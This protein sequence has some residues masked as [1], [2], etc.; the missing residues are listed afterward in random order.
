ML[1]PKSGHLEDQF[2]L[3]PL[4]PAKR[5][6]RVMNLRRRGLT[7]QIR[8]DVRVI[9][10][11]EEP[12]Y[13]ALSYTW[14]AT[15]KGH[16]ILLNDRYRLSITDNLHNALHRL[17]ARSA[18]PPIWVDAV[19]INQSDVPERSAQVE[20]MGDI[21]RQ[22]KTVR[23]WLGE[24]G[25]P[26]LGH[27]CHALSIATLVKT[28]PPT[29]EWH[30]LRSM[31]Y[32]LALRDANAVTFPGWYNRAW[33]QQEYALAR[34][35]VMHCGSL[36]IS[37]EDDALNAIPGLL[38]RL[39]AIQDLQSSGNLLDAIP[40]NVPRQAKDP[41]DLVYSLRA[42]LFPE[43][44]QLIV[45]DYSLSCETV[46][47]QAT[48]IAIR[49]SGNFNILEHFGTYRSLDLTDLG[50]DLPSWAVDF[51][52]TDWGSESQT[53]FVWPL[54]QEFRQPLASAEDTFASLTIQGVRFGAVG[55][56]L[57][58]VVGDESFSERPTGRF[59]IDRVAALKNHTGRASNG[60]TRHGK[61]ETTSVWALKDAC[62]ELY[63]LWRS[64][65]GESR[66]EG[67]NEDV[68]EIEKFF[69]NTSYLNP[70][71]FSVLAI[72]DDHIALAPHDVRT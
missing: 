41:R 5:Q 57:N 19:C 18:P 6:I 56:V 23:I 67:L 4:D 3:L 43:I 28:K 52:L 59:L 8:A 65:R 61:F 50:L 22:A 46:F 49:T 58:L 15:T 14:G 25:K 62:C 20:M 70:D 66:F 37:R 54:M 38:L 26:M 9:S 42:I 30:G 39:Q 34:E 60:S 45:P 51:S 71:G 69:W 72:R 64:H 27:W 33:T 32:K 1:T 68:A 55:A 47:A 35:A 16:T 17:R 44:S 31:A 2:P 10:L 36:E 53:E 24:P 11:D 40:Q 12:V 29:L 48:F 21:Y 63:R 7:F 13:E